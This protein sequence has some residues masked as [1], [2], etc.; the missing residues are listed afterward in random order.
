MRF[1]RSCRRTPVCPASK[2]STVTDICVELLQFGAPQFPRLGQH[3]EHTKP[4][5]ALAAF[6]DRLGRYK[7]AATIAG[8]ALSPL[9]AASF[10]NLNTTI[11]HLRDVLGDQTYESLARKGDTMTTAEIVTY[12]D[13]QIDRPGPSGAERRLESEHICD[14]TDPLAGHVIPL[15]RIGGCGTNRN[16]HSPACMAIRAGCMDCLLETFALCV[17]TA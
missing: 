4:L 14:S 6:F 1:R 13:D 17:K 8:F 2:P 12:G 15:G 10:P 3:H 16:P 9:T 7:A 5:A 11:T